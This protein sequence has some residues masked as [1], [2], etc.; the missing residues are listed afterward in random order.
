MN[1]HIRLSPN[2]LKVGVKKKGLFS[3]KEKYVNTSRIKFHILLDMRV[4][5]R[6]YSWCWER[7]GKEYYRR[8]SP[9]L[10]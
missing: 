3:N 9:K 2:K 4:T 10:K 1:N 7:R 8:L 5:K 6:K